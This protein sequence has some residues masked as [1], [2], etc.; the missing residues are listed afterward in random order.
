M[1]EFYF[2]FV[3]SWELMRGVVEVY[4]DTE[5]NTQG[6]LPTYAMLGPAWRKWM[7]PHMKLVLRNPISSF[8]LFLIE[9]SN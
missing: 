5:G 9:L 3:C 4:Q 7:Q 1:L 8:N 2:I 6:Q